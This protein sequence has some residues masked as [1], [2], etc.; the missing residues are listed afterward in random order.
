MGIL[1]FFGT[2]IKNDITST[3]IKPNF[4]DKMDINH[5]FLDFNSIIHVS[6]QKLI[7]DVNAFMQSVLKTIYKRWSINSSL[8]IEKF[9]KYKMQDIQKRITEDT[10]PY[11]ITQMFKEHFN[12]KFLD[13]LVITIVI[14]NILHLLRTY[15]KNDKLKTL[16]MAIDGVPSKGK[17]IEQRQRRYMGA[18][19]EIY[20][21]KILAKYKEYLLDLED[22]AY[23]STSESIKWSRNK[24]TPG[25]AFMHK[26]SRY[27]KHE[28]IQEKLKLNRE[29]MNLI[30]SDMYEIG[31][32]E[33]KIVNYINK[34][35]ART[36]DKV[37]VYSPDADM[38]LLCILLPIENI[39]V[40]R[41]NQQISTQIGM[42]TYDL[43][44]IRM[45]KKNIG[46]YINNHPKYSKE[47]FDT[48]KINND[49]VC[50]ST[51]FGNDF[52]PKMETLNVRKGFQNILDAYL[53]ALIKLKDRGYYLV[54]GKNSVS[55]NFNL[56]FTF[57]KEVI[58][59]LLPEENDFIKHNNLYA[60]YVTLGQ[61]KSVFDY[62]EI[63]SKNL[64][65]TYNEFREQYENLKRS[66]KH[67]ENITHYILNDRFMESLK[68]S[69]MVNMDG[70]YINTSFLSNREMAKLLIDYYRK[71][72]D[73][74]RLNINLNT[75]S[76]SISDHKHN[77]I[78]KEKRM[79]DYQKEIYKFE[80]MLD[81]Y[82]IKFNAQPLDLTKDKIG[83][84]YEDY[85]GVTILDDKGNLTKDA[86][87]IMEDYLE[88]MLWVFRYYFN[89]TSYIS[90]WYYEHER[91]PLMNHFIMFLDIIDEKYLYDIY[92]NLSKYQ[93]KNLDSYFNPLE[94]LI[95]VSPLT[96]DFLKLLPS[97]YR[98]Y[99][100]SKNIDPFI[101]NF[102]PDITHITNRLWEENISNDIDCR[103]IIFL[104][105]CMIKSIMKPSTN[106]DEQFLRYIRRI[107]PTKISQ[108]RSRINKPN[109]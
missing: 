40:L 4:K 93:I 69:V 53:K 6:S 49:I 60:Q 25:T 87:K 73:F 2:L 79:N 20:K 55:G 23:L 32:G 77:K 10:N 84:F 63:N 106:D 95:Y 36:K 27:L 74:P 8:L 62:M 91:A 31:E 99:F 12:D 92:T 26:L 82:Y 44:D 59:F 83:K 16:V 78:V 11:E 22:Y 86:M 89:D 105:K 9:K 76:H 101:K 81:N 108:K 17:M 85:F 7:T 41:H 57:L 67:H 3:S 61:I 34:Y 19:M 29:N 109:F 88:G 1:E 45:L 96:N 70:Q 51:L 97:N 30:I 71:Y 58:R 35:L 75:W 37:V 50:I 102:F 43:I 100:K 14:N 72:H 39:Y 47:T 21:K 24:I 98:K 28:K 54:N 64:V 46:Y 68:K 33:K 42:N 13:K 107:K 5:L 80:N 104:N 103:G 56:N 18:I 52:V 94:Q 65:T 15:C 90:S 38:I 48:D 66:I